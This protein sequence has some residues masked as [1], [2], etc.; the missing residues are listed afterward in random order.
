MGCVKETSKVIDVQLLSTV[1]DEKFN[2]LTKKIIDL[3]AKQ[4]AHRGADEDDPIVG[5]N[6]DDRVG[7]GGKDVPEKGVSFRSRHI[8]L[9]LAH[10]HS[11]SHASY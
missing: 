6:D 5:I 1:G 9:V 4:G 8:F 7:A 3:V 2:G 11:L 10:H